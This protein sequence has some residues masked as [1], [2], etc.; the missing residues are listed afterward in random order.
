MAENIKI[1]YYIYKRHIKS[2]H[3]QLTDTGFV[4]PD[5][6]FFFRHVAINTVTRYNR[7]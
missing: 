3:Q 6:S 5:L 2:W 7:N 4:T 1:K